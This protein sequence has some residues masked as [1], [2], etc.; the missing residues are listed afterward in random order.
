MKNKNERNESFISQ[1]PEHVSEERNDVNAKQED[2]NLTSPDKPLINPVVRL[3]KE[4]DTEENVESEKVF[5]NESEESMVEPGADNQQEVKPLKSTVIRLEQNDEAENV[6]DVSTDITGRVS[7]SE[8]PKEI[9]KIGGDSSNESESVEEVLNANGSDVKHDIVEQQETELTCPVLHLESTVVRLEKNLDRKVEAEKKQSISNGML[10]AAPEVKFPEKPQGLLMTKAI[11]S[12]GWQD[13]NFFYDGQ[14]LYA[15]DNKGK[16]H[17]ISNFYIQVL[18]ENVHRTEIVNEQNLIINIVDTS[19][20]Q[21]QIVCGRMSFMKEMTGTDLSSHRK[22]FDL[23]NGRAYIEDGNDSKKWYRRYVNYVLCNEHIEKSILYEKTGWTFLKNKGWVYLTDRGIVGE[24][25]TMYRSDVPQRFLFDPNRLGTLQIF[26]EFYGLRNLCVGERQRNSVFLMH[27]TTLATMTTL[28][29]ECHH[30][31]NFVTA[32]IGTT[33]SLKTATALIFARMFDRTARSIPDLRFDST[34]TAIREK[35]QQFGDAI[36]LIDDLL[37][38]ENGAQATA[39]LNKLEIVARSY[40]DRVPRKRSKEYAKNAGVSEYSR[41]QGCCIITGEVLHTNSE[42]TDTRII[43][44]PF[45]RGDVDK[46][47]LT[48]YQQNLSNVPD[49]LFD[50]ILFVRQNLNEVFQLIQQET[51]RFRETVT[52][53]IV[54]PRF[55][56]SFGIMAAETR[57]FYAYAVQKNFMTAEEANARRCED[58]NMILEI[59]KDNERTNKIG[60]ISTQLC[61]LLHTK[62]D[63]EVLDCILEEDAKVVERFEN[64]VVDKGEFFAVLPS[65]LWGIYVQYCKYRGFMV[66]YQNAVELKMPLMKSNLLLL[67]E[68][69]GKR[70]ASHKINANTNKRFWFIRKSVMYDLCKNYENQL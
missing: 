32:M 58:L 70:R 8:P 25:G 49:F 52:N 3:E 35:M 44:L 57:I 23:T 19:T 67:K 22:I 2:E 54:T 64:V 27:F 26:Q 48:F 21:V 65:T 68:E 60:D 36:L 12:D 9:Y 20:W 63:G 43:K 51:E 15:L 28:F 37:P 45:E 1:I 50:F 13:G 33:N 56:E 10:G 31:V 11:S 34:E 30:P 17:V 40:G 62:L 16:F 47:R 39:Q 6:G 41:V 5:S 18:H 53:V 69:S 66:Q 38:L 14:L 42:S 46:Q 55:R 24:G 4:Q 61:M 29:Q 59:L 7:D